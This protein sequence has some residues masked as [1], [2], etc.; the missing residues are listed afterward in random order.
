VKLNDLDFNKLAVF[1]Q[2]VESGNYRR[3]SEALGV[4][5]S[6]LSQTI[7]LLEHKLGLALFH[8]GGRKLVPTASGLKLQKEFRLHQG[9]FLE[10]VRHLAE[11][12]HRVSGILRV[13]SYLE[14]ATAQLA[15]RI[16]AF[17]QRFP[18]A[19]LKL[20]FESPSRLQGALEKGQLD[21]CFS[22]YP[23]DSKKIESRPVFHEELV[24]VAPAGMLSEEP[25]FREI[26]EAPLIEYFAS[27]QATTRWMQLHFR[28]RPKKMPVRVYAAAAEMVLA[29][30]AEGAGI[31][32]VPKFLLDSTRLKK[33][34]K[35]VRPTPRKL[36]DHIW[37][38][39][40]KTPRTR[41]HEEFRAHL[42]KSFGAQLSG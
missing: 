11:E 10:S 26:L 40:N 41:L 30:V 2:V 18:E 9:A 15:P 23:S 37:M 4:T 42:L 5:P 13:G 34:V 14:F 24:L 21:L 1:C 22:I 20:N 8:R 27:H 6:A 38:L 29:L 39:E 7:T 17:T 12:K 16:R 36:L 19:Q 25:H 3:A 33:S 32:V 35:I 31:G 28:K